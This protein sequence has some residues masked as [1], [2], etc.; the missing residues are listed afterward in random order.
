MIQANECRINNWVRYDNREFQIHA[1]A[2]E[3]PCL[4]TDEFGI[5]VVSWK[6]LEPIPL[7]PEILENCGFEKDRYGFNHRDEH[8]SFYYK[9][10][11]ANG[12]YEPAWKETLIG[13]PIKY[14]HQLQNLYFSLCGE[15]LIFKP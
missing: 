9:H 2:E 6:S 3:F 8:L 11:I 10:G 13:T 7:S 12:T 5:G 15:E 4:N 14:I 1:I